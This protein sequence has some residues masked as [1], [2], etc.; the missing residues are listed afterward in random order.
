MLAWGAVD[1]LPSAPPGEQVAFQLDYSG[2]WGKYYLADPDVRALQARYRQIRFTPGYLVSPTVKRLSADVRVRAELLEGLVRRRVRAVRR[3]A[4]PVVRDRVHGAGRELLGR[5]RPGSGRCPNYGSTPNAA[6]AVWELRL[7]HWTGALPG[8]R[9]STPTG[10]WHQWDHLYG[11]FPYHGL[12]VYGFALDRRPARRSTR[13]AATSTS[14][15]STRRTA[16][17]WKRENSFLTH[18]RHGR[19]LLQRQPARRP[20]GGQRGRSTARR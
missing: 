17:G 19:L 9:R 16:P 4:A 13:S 10:S 3:P 18:T 14:T 8:A 20:S 2:G 1:A 7:S 6:Q 11:T 12:P 15:R 5:C